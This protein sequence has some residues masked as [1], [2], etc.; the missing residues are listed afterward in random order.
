MNCIPTLGWSVCSNGSR[1][2][3]IAILNIH[4]HLTE[5]YATTF[6]ATFRGL[7]YPYP[8]FAQVKP[9]PAFNF[10]FVLSI[11]QLP[12][13]S[14]RTDTCSPASHSRVQDRCSPLAAGH[15]WERTC[16]LART[17]RSSHRKSAT[18]RGYLR[19]FP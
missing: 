7:H 2:T 8:S 6:R 15:L 3:L 18:C 17:C 4:Y 10:P 11:L 16:P 5:C 19:P 9:S 14:F 12:C 1:L 13:Q